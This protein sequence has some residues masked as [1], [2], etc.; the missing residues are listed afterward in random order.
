MKAILIVD[1]ATQIPALTFRL[2]EPARDASDT[3]GFILT[4]AVLS[5]AGFGRTTGDHYEYVCL[6]RADG[7]S[8][9]AE[10]DP[11]KWEDLMMRCAHLRLIEDWTSVPP[12]GAVDVEGMRLALIDAMGDRPQVEPAWTAG[13]HDHDH[14]G[15]VA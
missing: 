2:D 4:E 12:G 10:V 5:R 11:F 8:F 1:A 14:P 13:H 7:P 9:R 15:A 6:I 3:R